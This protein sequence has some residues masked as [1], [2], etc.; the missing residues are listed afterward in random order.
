MLRILAGLVYGA[1]LTAFAIFAVGAGDGTHI[2]I[3]LSSAPLGVVDPEA[4]AVGA[5]PAR[6]SSRK[7][8]MALRFALGATHGRVIG[9]LLTETLA[10][11]WARWRLTGCARVNRV[12]PRRSPFGRRDSQPCCSRACTS[13]PR[14][15]S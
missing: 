7:R 8:E 12:A 9:Q 2:L 5:L 6:S 14:R 4:S 1:V 15:P 11:F 3:G 13:T 10:L